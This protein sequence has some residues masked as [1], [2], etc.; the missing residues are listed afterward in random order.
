MVIVTVVTLFGLRAILLPK[1]CHYYFPVA[2]H[3]FGQC[4][5]S[6][7]EDVGETATTSK[8]YDIAGIR[9]DRVRGLFETVPCLRTVRVRSNAKG[10]FVPK[11][12]GGP[13]TA[14]IRAS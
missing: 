10:Q 11:S 9:Q 1:E 3:F 13:E 4:I 12:A 14:Q 6:C 5:P 8:H 7:S 2:S